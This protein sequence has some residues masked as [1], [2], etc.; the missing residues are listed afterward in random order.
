VTER[1]G[2]RNGSTECHDVSDGRGLVRLP[3]SGRA[4]LRRLYQA[5]RDLS[6]P[7]REWS[8]ESSRYRHIA[9][10]D[11]V[12]RSGAGSCA[13]PGGLGLGQGWLGSGRALEWRGGDR[14]VRSRRGTEVSCR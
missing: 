6:R 2:T 12:G 1:G 8:P 14:K 11:A 5:D 4:D 7:W 9:W 13:A 10:L 3:I